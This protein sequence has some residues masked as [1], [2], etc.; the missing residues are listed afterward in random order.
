MSK[1]IA[2]FAVLACAACAEGAATGGSI[3]Y[4]EMDHAAVAADDAAVP[5]ARFEAREAPA[6]EIG[7]RHVTHRDGDIL[8]CAQCRR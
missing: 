5:R 2:V 4:P 1:I 3:E 6:R 7:F 8:V